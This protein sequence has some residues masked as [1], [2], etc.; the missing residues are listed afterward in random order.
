M[1]QRGI[2]GDGAPISALFRDMITTVVNQDAAGAAQH[3]GQADQK[4]V[5]PQG[6]AEIR[7]YLRNEVLLATTPGPRAADEEQEV[8]NTSTNATVAELRAQLAEAR[9]DTKLAEAISRSDVKHA[10]MIGR[11]DAGFAELK[12]QISTVG[13]RLDG[14]EKSTAGLRT[15]IFGTGVAAIAVV[16]GILAYGS[17]VVRDRRRDA[18]SRKGDRDGDS[19]N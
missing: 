16:I 4:A 9:S 3:G 8:S 12:G 19:A 14:I 11:L 15:A 17:D 18:R 1:D 7:S 13:A 10:E 6:L 2:I 5:R